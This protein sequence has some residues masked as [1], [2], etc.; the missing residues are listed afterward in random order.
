MSKCDLVALQF[1]LLVMMTTWGSV[2]FERYKWNWLDSTFWLTYSFTSYLNTINLKISA[3]HCGNKLTPC[4]LKLT[5]QIQLVHH[6]CDPFLINNHNM[7]GNSAKKRL[8][9]CTECK[10]HVKL[11]QCF[12]DLTINFYSEQNNFTKNNINA[13]N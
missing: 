3:K 6:P 4:R 7:T 11:I 9:C 10:L 13:K 8:L 5:V 1:L 12:L 2:L